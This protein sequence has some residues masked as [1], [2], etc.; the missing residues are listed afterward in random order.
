MVPYGEPIIAK[1]GSGDK[2]GYTLVQ[3]IETSNISAHFADETQE[4]YLDVF[5]CKPYEASVVENLLVKYFNVR[6]VRIG[7][8]ERK[9]TMEAV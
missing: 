9:A 8:I 6:T 1:F 2:T 4:I 7:T 3:L 5:S